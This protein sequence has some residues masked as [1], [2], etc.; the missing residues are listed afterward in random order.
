MIRIGKRQN[1]AEGR[2]SPQA[3]HF[4]LASRGLRRKI[5]QNEKGCQR[6][7]VSEP[8]G[9]WQGQGA[10]PPWQGGAD[11]AGLLEAGEDVLPP[12]KSVA[13]QPLPFN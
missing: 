9:Q 11:S 10:V 6:F 1:P 12:L 8:A 2:G 7:L 3:C 5:P 13:Y 4:A